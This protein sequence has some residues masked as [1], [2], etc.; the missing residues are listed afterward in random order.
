MKF[1]AFV[2]CFRAD[3]EKIDAWVTELENGRW[4]SAWFNDHILAPGPREDEGNIALEGFTALSVAAGMTSKLRL[5][6]MV[7]GTPYR[8]P[9]LVAKMAGTLDQATR[10][11]FTLG[12]GAGWFKREHEAYG[13][14]FPPMKERQDRLQEAA[15][16]TRL[17]FTT[18]DRVTYTG[19]YYRLDDAP[20]N[21]TGYGGR[22]IEILIGG[23]GE[24][25]TLRTV[26]L[27]GDAM[28]LDGFAGG[29][30]ALE[31]YQHKVEVLA[32][33][34]ENVGRDPADIRHTLNVPIVITEDQRVMDLWISRYGPGTV[35]GPRNYIIDRLGEFSDAGVDEIIIDDMA[36]FGVKNSDRPAA[37]VA[38]SA[39]LMDEQILA[40][41]SS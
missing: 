16:L 8:N 32:K 25:R 41:F 14:D 7:L 39:R 18:K 4:Q 37:D 22:Q 11:R 1:G 2:D 13:F 5:G 9:A 35:V 23:N 3:W 30:M 38:E 21:P 26:A 33:H 20:F 17:L 24:K 28:N 36:T 27:Y 31:F 29:G 40:A 12:I 15:E 34:C 19:K 6:H 10:G